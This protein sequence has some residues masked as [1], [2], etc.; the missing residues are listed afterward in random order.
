MPAEPGPRL[1]MFVR[2]VIV[3][4]HVNDLADW[5]LDLDGIQ[6]PDE[7]L[8]PV[9]LHAASDH[10]AVEHVERGEQRGGAVPLVIMGHRPAES[11]L[12]RQAWLGAVERLYLALFIDA[13]HHRVRRR[14][15]YS[16]TMSRSLGMNSGS[17]DSLNCR[18][19]CGWSPCERQ[20]RCTEETLIRTNPAIAAAVQCVVSPGGSLCVS[21]T[22]RSPMAGGSGGT[23]EG[24]VLSCNRPSTPVCMNRSC[25]RHR[26]V[27][28]LAVCRMISLVP[29]PSAVNST[30]RA[31][32]T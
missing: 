5:D 12:D 23:R 13:E 25:Q 24:R 19:R 31:R 7:L 20:M 28:L 6:E 17:R 21:A 3:E 29:R 10:L 1:G 16:P 15:I 30:I 8:M 27:L 11:R 26:Q 2:A 9:T 4:D 22:T 14:S 18:T 32:H